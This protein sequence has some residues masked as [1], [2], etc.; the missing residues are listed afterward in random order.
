MEAKP[1]L[2][3]FQEKE[4]SPGVY[5]TDFRAPAVQ[6]PTAAI[7]AS[8]TNKI[9]SLECEIKELENSIAHLLKSNEELREALDEDP[10]SYRPELSFQV[11]NLTSTLCDALQIR[12]IGRRWKRTSRP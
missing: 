9:A 11:S 3:S 5:L 1:P 7:L 12:C 4:V 2:S 6:S 8:D 10:G